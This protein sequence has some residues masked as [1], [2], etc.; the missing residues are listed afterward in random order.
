MSA[1]AECT[2]TCHS[3]GKPDV[4]AETAAAFTAQASRGYGRQAK[5][6]E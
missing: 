6:E 2:R 1:L 5:C 3:V 4:A